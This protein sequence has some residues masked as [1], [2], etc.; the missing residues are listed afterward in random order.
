SSHHVFAHGAL[1]GSRVDAAVRKSRG[2][3]REVEAVHRDQALTKIEVESY[4]GRLDDDVEVPEQMGDRPV[5]MSCVRLG[6]IDGVVDL[7]LPARIARVRV[8]HQIA[9]L[10]LAARDEAGASDRPGVD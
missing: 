10:L 2:D 9:R 7:E 4:L 1:T 5:P 3:R 6:L 8:E